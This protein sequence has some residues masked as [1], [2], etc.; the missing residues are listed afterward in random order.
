MAWLG[1]V[2]PVQTSQ[3]HGDGH[4]LIQ[5]ASLFLPRPRLLTLIVE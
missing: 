5:L 2:S 1:G 3:Q 4:K